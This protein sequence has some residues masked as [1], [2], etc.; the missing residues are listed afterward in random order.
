MA[1]RIRIAVLASGRGTDFQ[2]II[3]AVEAGDLPVDIVMLI[4]N[5][6][7]AQCLERASKHGIKSHTIDHHGLPREEH[8]RKILKVLEGKDI[9]LVVLAG[10][11]RLLAPSFISSFPDRII[12][13]HPSLLPS[14][15]GA[16]AHRDVLAH[17]AKVS[18]CTVHFVDAGEDSGPIIA[19]RAVPVMEDDTEETL[20]KRVLEVEH[21][22]LPEVIRLIAEGRVKLE[23]RK[24]RILPEN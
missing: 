20:S 22:L 24:V 19:Q 1:Q 21:Q 9:D 4:C 5:T 10:Y 11:M 6:P 15:P 13:I 8:E 3:D 23:D 18:G 12:N 16:H 14:F 17:G 7:G 2:S